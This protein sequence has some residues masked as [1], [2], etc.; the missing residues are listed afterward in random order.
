MVDQLTKGQ[1]NY[2]RYKKSYAGYRNTHR[3]QQNEL[4]SNYR[5]K[6]RFGGNLFSTLERD[7]YRCV[8]CGMSNKEHQ[9]TWGRTITVD[10]ID[11]N[12]RYSK[13]KNHDLSNLQTLCLRCHGIKDRN[14]DTRKG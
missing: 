10:H 4:W 2:R 9:E 8:K 14:V 3:I 5:N 12:G 11:G 7:N 6:T 13:V 1:I